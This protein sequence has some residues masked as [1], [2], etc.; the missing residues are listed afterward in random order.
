LVGCS[1]SGEPAK[2]PSGSL[3]SSFGK[4]GIATTEIGGG[5]VSALAVQPDGKIVV[6]GTFGDNV[7]GV[8]RY[9]SSG[10]LDT[11]FGFGGIATTAIGNV[12]AFAFSLAL[13]PDGK[14]V[15]AG[16]AQLSSTGGDIALVRYTPVG[17][18]DEAFGTG[19]IVTTS[20]TESFDGAYAVALQDDG[21]I[22]VAGYAGSFVALA[23]YTA[24]GEL[25][26]SFDGDG[27]VETAING[28]AYG[29]AIQPDGKIV[30]G[31]LRYS[32]AD[33]S[34]FVL[35]RFTA[36]G[37]SDG[38]F[39]ERGIVATA[40]SG[41]YDGIS[42]IALQPEGK[43]VAVGTTSAHTFAIVRYMST[44]ALDTSFDGD[45]IVT[46]AFGDGVNGSCLTVQP[47]GK[48][49]VA[50]NTTAGTADRIVVARYLPSGALDPTFGNSGIVSTPAGSG[51]TVVSGVAQQDGK[52][53]VAGRTE[54]GDSDQIVIARYHP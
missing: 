13:Q 50:G 10:A 17:A 26:A 46:T 53:V 19:G 44:G 15:V 35:A 11:S 34:L 4:A 52:I 48:I 42:G 7:F 41:S 29:L 14:I 33:A 40:I 21:K 9:T 23:R 6:A 28:Q 3:D 20:V 8:A 25:D 12:P 43:I 24:A 38:S 30:A 36:S 54:I 51:E 1:S 47:D 32:G 27:I 5:L 2:P 18:L 37:A 22:V 45:G 31:G 16:S 49:V 39:G